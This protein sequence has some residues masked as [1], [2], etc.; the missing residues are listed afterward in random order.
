MKRLLVSFALCALTLPAVARAELPKNIQAAIVAM[1]HVNDTAA[2]GALFASMHKPVPADIKI[3]RD[4]SYGADPLQKLDIFTDGKGAG[5]PILLYVHGGGFTGGDKHA[6]D[7]FASD[8]I[9]EWAVKN[10]MVAAQ[11]NYRLA[12]QNKYPDA[13]NDVAAALKYVRD[14]ARDYGGDP[15]KIFLWGHSAGASLV[16]IY[17][18]HPQ[19]HIAQDGGL[20]GAIMTSGGYEFKTAS[21]YLGDDPKELAERSSVEG[22][23]K[24]AIPLFFTRAEWD[25]PGQ[26]QQGDMITK[27][28]CDIGK[29]PAFKLMMGH[30]HMSQTYSVNTAETQL[31]G[32][33]LPWLKQHS[34]AKAAS[35]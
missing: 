12:P 6:K 17:V 20:V 15:S 22:L 19:F 35:N 30:N 3:A 11:T 29:C 32:I 10:G 25:P 1:G 7:F 5:K 21:P 8:N 4:I 31:T 34:A 26:M 13:S 23:K 27:T 24:T 28:L 18:A 9:M 2:T 14:H 33:L 16:G